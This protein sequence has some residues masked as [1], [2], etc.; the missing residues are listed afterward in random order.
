MTSVIPPLIILLIVSMGFSGL[1]NASEPRPWTCAEVRTLSREQAA[2][3]LPV[4][5]RGIVTYIQDKR[6]LVVQDETDGLYI[7]A[8]ESQFDPKTQ[9]DVQVGS[10]VEVRGIS[11]PGGF[12]PVVYAD[13]LQ[14]LGSGVLPPAKETVLADLGSGQFDC[15]RVTLAGV[16]QRA[17]PGGPKD[18]AMRLEIATATG[19]FSAFIK[20]PGSLDAKSLINTDI[21]IT[22]IC[23]AFTN[24]RGELVGSLLW[25]NDPSHLR[26]LRPPPPDPFTAPEVAKLALN[27]YR[28]E[29]PNL[30]RQRLKGTVTLSRQGDF[31]YVEMEQRAV[32]VNTSSPDPLEPGDLVEASGF[33]KQTT[34]FALVDAAVFRKTG[35]APLPAPLEVTPHQIL[36]LKSTD[37]NDILRQEDY[38]GKLI[39]LHGRLLN[40]E[41]HAGK[42][43]QLLLKCDD[44]IVVATLPENTTA[45][46]LA[47]FVPNSDLEATG[48]CNLTLKQDWPTRIL[49]IAGNFTLILQNTISLRILHRP[50]WWTAERLLWALAGTITLLGSA[51]GVIGF[52]QRRIAQRTA[53]L[54]AEMKARTEKEIA[55]HDAE[56]EFRATNNERERLAADL[57]DTIA[58]T[59]TGIAMQLDATQRA[60]TAEHAQRNLALASHMLALS[61]EDVRRSVWNLRALALE[62]RFLREAVRHIAAPILEETHIEL[63]VHGSGEEEALPDLVVG[64]LLMLTKEAITNA[65]K[66]A[67]PSRIVVSVDYL[68]DSVILAIAD[69]G[70]GFSVPDAPGPH[71]GHFGLTG[72]RERAAKLAA[73]VHIV[74]MPGQGTQISI[75]TPLINL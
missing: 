13:S 60:P 38:D 71:H 56:V 11:V 25:L 52:L 46:R 22:G 59:L 16:I 43:H 37:T 9:S 42:D 3:H 6:A 63:L 51:L 68:P 41:S 67:A 15:H 62:G 44:K 66:H 35:K 54:A 70:C 28:P 61:R 50:S 48:I 2:K 8:R 64:N 24:P 10:L 32:R 53:E 74:S 20:A 14:L 45:D 31:F 39:Q 5:V 72:M 29:G 73:S 75:T 33:V 40:I 47:Q 18:P 69:D 36:A 4:L 12:A 1:L 23:Y 19:E 17:S 58:Q 57:H 26:I 30:H 55:L 65:L 34:G 49:P 7:M 21:Q 27:P